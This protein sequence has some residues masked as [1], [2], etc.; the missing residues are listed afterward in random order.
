MSGNFIIS[1]IIAVLG[2]MIG[3]VYG[4]ISGDDFIVVCWIGALIGFM[5]GALLTM[6]AT[7]L[8]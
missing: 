6:L 2:C 3:G 5:V 7:Q 8:S 4:V 1:A